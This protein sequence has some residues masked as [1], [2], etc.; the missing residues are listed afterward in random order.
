MDRS[1]NNTLIEF[2]L[3]IDNTFSMGKKDTIKYKTYM[4][5]A[6]Y[7]IGDELKAVDTINRLI[8]KYPNYD[9]P[10][11]VMINWFLFK[12]KDIAKLE[13]IVIKARNNKHQLISGSFIY[14]KLIDH[15]ENKDTRKH[16]RYKKQYEQWLDFYNKRH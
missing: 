9:E 11:Q 15:Y 13:G 14:E 8:D 6:Y 3:R 4:A 10:Y 2:V 5:D 1:I 7:D 16:A 12:K